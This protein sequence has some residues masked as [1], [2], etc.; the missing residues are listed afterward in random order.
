[1]GTTASGNLAVNS[2][3]PGINLNAWN[4]ITL[5]FDNSLA[6]NK[7]RFTV[8][9]VSTALGGNTAGVVPLDKVFNS[10]QGVCLGA[11]YNTGSI[12]QSFTGYIDEFRI[13]AVNRYSNT[14]FTPPTTQFATD[15]NTVLL[16]RLES[17]YLYN[18][19]IAPTTTANVGVDIDDGSVLANN[20]V[21]T[22]Y[23]NLEA[24]A[25]DSV[26]KLGGSQV[27][28]SSTLNLGGSQVLSS[29]T[30]GAT[31]T[32]A[33]LSSI[34][35]AGGIL[36]ISGAIG[37]REWGYINHNINASGG[38]TKN[39]TVSTSGVYM[40]TIGRNYNDINIFTSIWLTVIV[41]AGTGKT[42]AIYVPPGFAVNIN[43]IA[44]GFSIS[45]SY[46]TG[47]NS[48]QVQYIHFF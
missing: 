15:A 37:F 42:G 30:L 21:Y 13:S 43:G 11:R 4:H 34:T 35:P 12:D 31:V 5:R 48:F 17:S 2:I 22:R 46:P 25:S 40:F 23:G 7:Y 16:N 47:Y 18:S 9:G 32:N 29:S 19:Q 6:T 1:M 39:V 45:S 8:N 10:T 33:S 38:G 3:V 24:R 20:G 27:L 36:G 41:G 28:S 26:V 14:N 44:N